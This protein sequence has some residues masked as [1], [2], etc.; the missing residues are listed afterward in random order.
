VASNVKGVQIWSDGSRYDGFWRD[1]MAN[2]YGK[3]VHAESDFEKGE[4]TEDK[5]YGYGVYTHFNGSR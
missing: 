2:G 1:G 5:A 3:L 4:W